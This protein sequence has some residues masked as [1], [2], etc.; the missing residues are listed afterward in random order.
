[1]KLQTWL[2]ESWVYVPLK[3][4]LFFV[5]HYHTGQYEYPMSGNK[6]LPEAARQEELFH[7][8]RVVEALIQHIPEAHTF[9]YG[10]AP[11]NFPFDIVTYKDDSARTLVEVTDSVPMAE[12]GSAKN[13][14]GMYTR[15]QIHLM[16]QNEA[17]QNVISITDSLA[18]IERPLFMSSN[19]NSTSVGKGIFSFLAP[20]GIYQSPLKIRDEATRRIGIYQANKIVSDYTIALSDINM[21]LSVEKT[22]AEGPFVR[23]GLAI[24]PNPARPFQ[25]G[26]PVYFYYEMYHLKF[27]EDGRAGYQKI[28]VITAKEKQRGFFNNIITGIGNLIRR[29]HD[30][31]SVTMTFEG[32]SNTSDAA[33]SLSV[34]PS[35][36]EPGPY[37]VELAITDNQSGQTASKTSE[38]VIVAQQYLARC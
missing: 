11:L 37:T 10:G 5:D 23:H 26:H 3:M 22:G 29:A 38:F 2:A 35:V 25:Q 15:L 17:Y 31:R 36:M 1:M 12:I 28:V 32:E 18:L 34:D 4:E 19:N 27:A 7:P 6:L 9:D 24:S 14:L 16:L 33:D 30:D 20:A 21:A 13:G 8:K